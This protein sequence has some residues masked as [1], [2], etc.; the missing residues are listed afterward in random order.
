MLV[1]G[2]VTTATP[3]N[4]PAAAGTPT[5]AQATPQVI[6]VTPAPTAEVIYVTPAPTLEAGTPWS[7]Y[8]G[9]TQGAIEAVAA[10]AGEL[11]TDASIPELIDWYDGLAALAR[12]EQRWYASHAPQDCYAEHH[13]K[14]SEVWEI[15][16]Y[17]GT[18]GGRAL[19]VL[20]VA[21]IEALNAEVESMT[22]AID[23]SVVLLEQVDCGVSS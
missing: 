15:V 8:N 10:Q 4:S 2:C 14:V 1:A 18:E 17:I 12:A 6:Y 9:H 16:A 23:Q 11:P 7:E 5:G 13:A 21:A 22:R 20:D 19:R 3:T